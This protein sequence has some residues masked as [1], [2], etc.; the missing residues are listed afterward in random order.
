M[1]V[2]PREDGTVFSLTT[3]P[4][5]SSPFDV[6]DIKT[7]ATTRDILDAIHNARSH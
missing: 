4:R 2:N 3:K 5:K 6:P 1:N 7:Q